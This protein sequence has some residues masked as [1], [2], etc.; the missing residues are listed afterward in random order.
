[1]WE[2]MQEA[3]VTAGRSNGAVKRRIVKWARGVGLRS[4]LSVM[5]GSVMMSTECC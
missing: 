2:K 3:M 1:V 4:N 5:R